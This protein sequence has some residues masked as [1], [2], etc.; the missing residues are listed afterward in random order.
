[1]IDNFKGT[2]TQT[3]LNHE[4]FTLTFK[5]DVTFNRPKPHEVNVNNSG[6]YGCSVWWIPFGDWG[7][8]IF[9]SK[10]FTAKKD[11][12][13]RLRNWKNRFEELRGQV[14]VAM[15]MGHIPKVYEYG[16]VTH[17]GMYERG[18]SVRKTGENIKAYY[19]AVYMKNY[20]LLSQE[21]YES[22][23]GQ[24]RRNNLLRAFEEDGFR[25][26]LKDAGRVQHLGV[27]PETNSL[28]LL[29]IADADQMKWL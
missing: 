8:K 29:D 13:E 3:P 6:C 1:M 16:I 9:N 24:M 21:E 27:N 28:V 14:G 17:T 12:R 20:R 22:S 5:G 26:H 23:S 7:I 15:T 19:P 10:A 11:V 2:F 25:L 4:D 18:G